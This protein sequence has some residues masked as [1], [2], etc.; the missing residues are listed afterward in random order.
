MDY[1]RILTHAREILYKLFMNTT[2]LIPALTHS[3][4]VS[5][6]ICNLTLDKTT[7]WSLNVIS[8]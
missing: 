8:T 4:H 5:E 1:A 3:S 6:T 7:R 2:C